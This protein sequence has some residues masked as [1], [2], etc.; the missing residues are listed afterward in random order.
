MRSFD[1]LAR[2]VADQTQAKG[3]K[4]SA[5]ASARTAKHPDSEFGMVI[6]SHTGATLRRFPIRTPGDVVE[7]SAWLL[8]QKPVLP[9]RV[10]KHSAARIVRRAALLE[11]DLHSIGEAGQELEKLA[12]GGETEPLFWEETVVPVEVPA[13]KLSASQVIHSWELIGLR[14]PET[15]N[16]A[17]I[18]VR[19]LEDL[20]AAET[21]LQTHQA[22]LSSVDRRRMARGVLEC[23]R[24]IGADLSSPQFYEKRS[25]AVIQYAGTRVREEARWTIQERARAVSQGEVVMDHGELR[26]K[27]SSAYEAM[28]A[29]I[30]PEMT[31]EEAE[32]IVERVEML[33]RVSGMK[34]SSLLSPVEAMFHPIGDGMKE[35]SWAKTAASATK[36]DILY[37]SGATVIRRHQ[38]ESLAY[39]PLGPIEEILG[40]EVVQELRNDPSGVFGGLPKPQKSVIAS[41]IL[42]RGIGTHGESMSLM[43]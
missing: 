7:S 35:P 8:S 31:L 25:Q 1:D 19:N 14:D 4:L 36:D 24:R 33:D 28:A 20:S 16:S 3:V 9:E 38:V 6:L 30:T 13:E 27:F 22:K 43:E 21:F 32:E 12:S 23:W 2:G 10:A 18:V 29:R 40:E 17:P 15:G 42:D 37:S 26:K 41:Y 11:V 39:V 5:A 34:V